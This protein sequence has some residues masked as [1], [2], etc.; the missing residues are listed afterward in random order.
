MPVYNFKDNYDDDM[1]KKTLK[2]LIVSIFIVQ[3]FGCTE[4]TNDG[5]ENKELWLNE[6]IL[7]HLTDI[8]SEIISLRKEIEAL[9]NS[10]PVRN[11][12]VKSITL[13]SN[14]WLN[15]GAKYAIVEFSDYQCPFC[16]RHANTVF[17]LL[18]EKYID[19]GK[20]AYQV[21]DF[22]LSFH[23][24]G[25]L[26]AIAA[27]CAGQQGKYWQMHVKL[28]MA[29]GQL[30][31]DYFTKIA[32]EL[33]LNKGQFQ[34]CMQNKEIIAQV[35]EDLNYGNSIGVSGTPRFFIG[36]V[37]GDELTQITVINGAQSFDAFERVIAKLQQQ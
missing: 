16:A 11:Q 28:L 1:R 10:K 36:K 34:A 35:D 31:L 26:A 8:K 2:I 24:Q 20:L 22:P 32:D 5:S 29:K 37:S 9:K 30:G 12:A 19:T 3:L 17:P 14:H 25:K 33:T 18:K 23:P 6:E 13:K 21:R 15:E 27:R 7:N 4:S